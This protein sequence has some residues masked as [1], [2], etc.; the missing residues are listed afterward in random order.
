MDESEIRRMIWARKEAVD[1]KIA[2]EGFGDLDPAE[3][4]AWVIALQLGIDFDLAKRCVDGS[5]AEEESAAVRAK[6]AEAFQYGKRKAL[7]SL[8]TAVADYPKL[9][10]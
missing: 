8:R 10:E 6:V 1:A 9:R 5:A 3:Q 7:R 2:E 4:D